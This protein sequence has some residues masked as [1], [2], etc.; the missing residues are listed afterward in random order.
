M[1]AE[2][3]INGIKIFDGVENDKLFTLVRPTLSYDQSAIKT[4]FNIGRNNINHVDGVIKICGNGFHFSP[5][6]D[7]ARNNKFNLIVSERYNFVSVPPVYRVKAIAGSEID[8]RPTFTSY[9]SLRAE[10]KLA[11]SDLEIISPIP[12]TLLLNHLAQDRRVFNNE[13]IIN[14][15]NNTIFLDGIYNRYFLSYNT[16]DIENITFKPTVSCNNKTNNTLFIDHT[17]IGLGTKMQCIAITNE[18]RYTQY[19]NIV[20]RFEQYIF[21]IP[22]HS[23]IKIDINIMK[24]SKKP[25]QIIK[26]PSQK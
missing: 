5:S 18:T 15:K 25:F 14:H 16:R 24:S 23:K 21:N 7:D 20:D 26:L 1:K 3:D 10:N 12:F 2:N 8:T 6:Y 9:G 13:E 11:T 4:Y 22:R 17:L 19:V